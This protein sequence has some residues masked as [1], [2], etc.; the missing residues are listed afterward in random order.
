MEIGAILSTTGTRSPAVRPSETA[1]IRRCLDVCAGA[2]AGAFGASGTVLLEAE[3]VLD[4]AEEAARP[5]AGAWAAASKY[6]A[7][8]FSGSGAPA[9]SS[10]WR[11]AESPRGAEARAPALSLVPFAFP[12]LAF[13][14]RV[15]AI[16]AVAGAAVFAAALSIRTGAAPAERERE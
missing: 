13:R 15:S 12:P 6:S 8:D 16:P 2:A 4:S 5:F 11:R 1:A 3:A 9:S 10:K 7:P 14:A